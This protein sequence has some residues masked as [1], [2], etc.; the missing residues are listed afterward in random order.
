LLLAPLLYG[1]LLKIKE[2]ENVIVELSSQYEK[3]TEELLNNK[4]QKI[5]IINSSAYYFSN[6]EDIYRNMLNSEFP[7]IKSISSTVALPY[8][9]RYD[10]D[11]VIVGENFDLNPSIAQEVKVEV[12]RGAA[13]DQFI[14]QSIHSEEKLVPPQVS[15]IPGDNQ[16]TIRTIDSREGS[17]LRCLHMGSYVGCYP[18]PRE[19]RIKYNTIRKIDRIDMVFISP[20]GKVSS[21]TSYVL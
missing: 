21:A 6:L 16:L 11:T 5:L 9:K 1:S 7:S 8:I 4:N 20:E 10:F 12:F 17:Y 2:S 19:Y 13:A 15:F 14:T 3:A 18:V